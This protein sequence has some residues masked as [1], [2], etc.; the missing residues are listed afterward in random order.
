MR[1]YVGS[2]GQQRLE[3]AAGLRNGLQFYQ[4]LNMREFAKAGVGPHQINL[5]KYNF[6]QTHA[7]IASRKFR[8]LVLMK[9][10]GNGH[11][12]GFYIY[13]SPFSLTTVQIQANI[14]VG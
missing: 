3:R 1:S 10:K 2:A 7:N 14:T 5:E 11:L 9:R 8:N 4:C 12:T 13:F 6:H